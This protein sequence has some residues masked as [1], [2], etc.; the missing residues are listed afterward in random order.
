MI[1]CANQGMLLKIMVQVGGVL[2]R[3]LKMDSL[4][5]RILILNL[6]GLEKEMFSWQTEV[7]NTLITHNFSLHLRNVI[8]FIPTL[9]NKTPKKD[10]I[11]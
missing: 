11:M 3:K 6:M 2:L 9:K 5:M 1:S 8:G 4:Q 7:F 10:V